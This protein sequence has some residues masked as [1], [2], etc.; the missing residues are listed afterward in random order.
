MKI[1]AFCLFLLL[2]TSVLVF[3]QD[4]APKNWF[5]LD[6]TQ[7]GYPGLS[8]EKTYKELLKGKSGKT[9]VVAVIDSGVD[10]EHED[11]KDIMWVNPGEIAGNGID[12]DKN[13][14][15][16]DIHGWNF[17]GGKDGRNVNN[18]NLEVTRLYVRYKKKY[19]GKDPAKLSKAERAEYDTYKEYEK[20]IEKKQAELGPQAMQFGA[21]L[22]GFKKFQ[23]QVGK[24]PKAIT[25]KD[26]ENFKSDDQ[27][28]MRIATI[29]KDAMESGSTFVEL[30]E[31]I[32]GAVD[33]FEGQVKYNYNPDFDAR[34]IVGDDPLNVND[35][36]YG[37]NDVKGPDASHGTHVAGIIGAI[38]NNRIGIDGVAD[39]VRIMSVRTV[40][41]GDER[42][43]DVAN[44]IRYAVDN[45]ATVINMSFGKGASPEKGAVDAAVRYA[46]E[47]DVV[48]VH[49]AGNDNK[50]NDFENN[51]P[52]DRFAKKGLFGKK[53]AENWIEVG[54]STWMRDEHLTAE[55]SNYSDDIVDVFAPGFEIYSTMP[56]NNYKDQQGTS[57]ASPMVAGVAALIRSYYPEL[58]AKQ[59]KDIIMESSTPWKAKVLKPGTEDKVALSELSVTGGLVNVYDA[60]KLASQT[61]G[62]KKASKSGSTSG[63][64]KSEKKAASP[65][66]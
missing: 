32:Q 8:T 60:V 16:D 39:N 25:A 36:N 46:M 30:M 43:K 5:N 64:G 51:F 40:P 63:T 17:I 49:A 12:D 22:E 6:L 18:E 11:L 44:A 57:M 56:E 1:K 62:K 2:S 48:L 15:I 55:F 3:A 45:G 37:N 50:E 54:A 14:Y 19:E 42:D 10:A 21:I 52:N 35:R 38:R 31:E 61:K 4:S 58:S 27:M 20:V 24:D 41:N 53:Y 65:K 13:G 23:Q 66:A 59:V 29:A 26:A 34:H 33:Y 28:Q 9:V 47:R 7:D